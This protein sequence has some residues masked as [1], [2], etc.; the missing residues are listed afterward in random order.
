MTTLRKS[1]RQ[2]KPTTTTIFFF[3]NTHLHGVLFIINKDVLVEELNSNGVERL[4][5]KL[6]ADEAI[7]QGGLAHTTISQQHHL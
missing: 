4:G 1:T 5:I 7:H 6:V 3:L 2:R